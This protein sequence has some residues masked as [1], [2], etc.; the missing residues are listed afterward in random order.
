MNGTSNIDSHTP[1]SQ[2]LIAGLAGTIA[3]T[4]M[5]YFGATMM[6]GAPM[7]IAGEL[8]RLIGAPWLLGM[9]MHFI[10]GAVVFPCAYH[11]FVTRILR[12]AGIASGLMWGIFLWLIAMFIMSPMMGKGLFMGAMPAA[13]ASL[14]G[15]M[16]YG[17]ILG[18]ILSQPNESKERIDVDPAGGM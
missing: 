14:V 9:V 12:S 1:V 2:I 6:I 13:L 3:L 4:L 10:L 11:L 7:D 18:K 5:M 15:H 8:A 16:A 17:L